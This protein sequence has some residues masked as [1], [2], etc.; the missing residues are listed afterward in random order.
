[1]KWVHLSA[2]DLLRAERLKQGSKLADEINACIT[3]GKLVASEVTCQLLRNAMQYAFA[4]KSNGESVSHFL[5]DGFPRSQS[6]I[7]AWNATLSREQYQVVAVL[8]YVCPEETLIGRLLERGKSSGR[9]DDNLASVRAR[10]A[11][12]AKETA[13]LLDYYIN[14]QSEIPVYTIRTDRPVEAV[15]SETAQLQHFR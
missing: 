4:N 2:G 6:N 9:A 10:F 3:A 12:F 14:Q 5:I 8:N 13:P 1:V 15:Y 7:D 11:T